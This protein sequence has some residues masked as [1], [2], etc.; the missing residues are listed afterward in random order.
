MRGMKFIGADIGKVNQL[1]HVS[2]MIAFHA[3]HMFFEIHCLAAE[4]KQSSIH[5][6][7]NR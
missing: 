2:G 6:A 5:Y 3:A 4:Q 1:L 7:L